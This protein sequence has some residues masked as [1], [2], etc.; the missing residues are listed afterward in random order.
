MDLA[1]ILWLVSGDARDEGAGRL[2]AALTVSFGS[3]LQ[4]LFASPNPEETIPIIGE[5]VSGGFVDEVRSA[6]AREARMREAEARVLYDLCRKKYKL[7]EAQTPDLRPENGGGSCYFDAVHGK[8]DQTV[9]LRGRVVDLVVS[10]LVPEQ[11]GALLTFDAALL[12]TGRPLLVA[13]NAASDTLPKRIMIAWN[14]SIEVARAVASALP[15]LRQADHVMIY[16]IAKQ[17]GY[18]EHARQLRDSLAW[19]GITA[20]LE[21]PAPQ[22]RPVADMLCDMMDKSD[23]DLLVMGAYGHSRMRELILGGVTRKNARKDE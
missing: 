13:P 2:A 18:V 4:V 19:R 21:T 7:A 23:Y 15:L 3:H 14:G 1:T 16:S 20:A 17:P 10:A 8:E 6:A 22:G 12:E 11:A 9:G 5:G